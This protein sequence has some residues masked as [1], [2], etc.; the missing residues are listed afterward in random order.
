M[1][2]VIDLSAV[3][4]QRGVDTFTVVDSVERQQ[5]Q[6]YA[7]IGTTALIEE[8][9]DLVFRA[10]LANVAEKLM[11]SLPEE[12]PEEETAGGIIDLLHQQA[13]YHGESEQIYYPFDAV[14]IK[15][16]EEF[17]EN[18]PILRRPENA[19]KLALMW[20]VS[21]ALGQAVR[22]GALDESRLERTV[23]LEDANAWSVNCGIRFVWS[24]EQLSALE[25]SASNDEITET[26]ARDVVPYRIGASITYFALKAIAHKELPKE[27]DATGN[28]HAALVRRIVQSPLRTQPTLAEAAL[29]TPFSLS[30]AVTIARRK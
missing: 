6:R 23:R 1:G 9:E 24:D 14:V 16:R 28:L 25:D 7:T 21:E 10:R 19:R 3:K 22:M 2:D 27:K 15:N 17:I 12:T 11:L 13:E 20:T 18:N 26:Y 30:D 5:L 4:Q 29:L 8:V